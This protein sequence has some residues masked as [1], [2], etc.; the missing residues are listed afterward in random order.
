MQHVVP[1]YGE[2]VKGRTW[3]SR[4]L[5][6]VDPW[7]ADRPRDIPRP[8]AWQSGRNADFAAFLPHAIGGEVPAGEAFVAAQIALQIA[9]AGGPAPPATLSVARFVYPCAHGTYTVDVPAAIPTQIYLGS[10]ER[11]YSLI[12]NAG[13]NDATLA[14]GRDAD[15][16][17]QP[18]A[19]AGDG[20]HELPFGT[21][22][23]ASVF[24]LLGTRITVTDGRHDPPLSAE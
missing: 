11:A 23:S 18:L 17:S 8:V 2:S 20:F 5:D 15:A 9:D 3:V 12:V 16:N 6:L 13:A 22:S 7:D 1:Y 4:A 19:N 14:Y 21:T 24:S 10:R